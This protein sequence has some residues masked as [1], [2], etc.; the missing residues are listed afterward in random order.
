MIERKRFIFNGQPA[1]G[2]ETA[3]LAV[4]NSLLVIPNLIISVVIFVPSFALV[5]W[6]IGITPIGVWVAAGL[7]LLYI[8]VQSEDLYKIGDAAGFA[9]SFLSNSCITS[10]ERS[11]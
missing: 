6:I 4:L 9:K 5:G 2:T 3:L 1:I 10:K 7:K 8:N 11:F